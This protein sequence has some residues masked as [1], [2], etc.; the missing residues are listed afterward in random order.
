MCCVHSS[1]MYQIIQNVYS[2]Y[3]EDLTYKK[4]FVLS[5][6]LCNFFYSISTITLC[7]NKKV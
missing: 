7:Y 4:T 2:V 6:R 3:H 5:N 1:E